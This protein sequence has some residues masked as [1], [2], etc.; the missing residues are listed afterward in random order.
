MSENVLPR[1]K[2][3]FSETISSLE[4]SA[5]LEITSKAK[6]MVKKGE[7]V[8][9]LAAGEPD[10]DTPVSV[11]KAALQ[12][13]ERGET[14][15]TPAAGTLSLRKAIA[16]KLKR[17][18]GVE[19]SP[20]EIV[21]S[22]GAKHSIYNTLRVLCNP[23]DEVIVVHPYWLSYPEMVT[24]AGGKPVIIN[25]SAD[26][27]F[28]VSPSDIRKAVTSKTKAIIINSPSNPAGAVYDE[29]ELRD[30]AE[31]CLEKGV[32]I[33]SD[34]IYEK[35]M[36]DGKKHFSIAAVSAAVRDITVVING[37]SKGYAMTGWRIGYAAAER[38]LA[39]LISNFQS[40]TTSN[41]CSISQAAAEYA[42]T[43]LELEDEIKRNCA[44][45]R[46]RRDVMLELFSGQE[47]IKPFIPLGAFYMF[48]DVSRTG[49]G[50]VEFSERLLKEK[51]VAVI[52]GGPFGD[53]K[54]VRLSFAT[55]LE[56]IKKGVGRITQWVRE[57]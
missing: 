38:T 25:T 17:D 21:V 1:K 50:S 32:V 24:L 20:G 56:T 10:F 4:P 2:I 13:M 39:S 27:G 51:K 3:K 41:P 45:Y 30:I 40:Q 55:D 48:C 8:V 52:P 37:V 7:D 46:K 47:K 23:G 12:A 9:I 11:R 26:A 34:E 49:M 35:I 57:A 36:F 15:Y 54:Y 42:M 22:C 5:T 28:R 18:N 44:E 31:V 14:R 33:I 19:Y 6:D 43:S 53:D 29:K 16:E